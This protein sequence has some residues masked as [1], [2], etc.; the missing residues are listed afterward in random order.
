[1]K[2]SSSAKLRFADRLVEWHA[3]SG[4]HDLPWQNTRD[5]YLIWISEIMLQQTQVK[6]VIPYFAR[7]IASFPTVGSLAQADEN[8]VLAH[9]SGLGYYARG[10]NLLKAARIIATEHG[11][12]FPRAFDAICALP[13]VGRSTASAISAFAFDEKRAILDGNVKRVLSRCF[14]IEGY[15]GEKK[16]E[17]RLWALAEELL[18]DSSD[19]IKAYTQAQMDLGATVCLRSRPLCAGCPCSRVCV[20]NREKRIDEFPGRKPRRKIPSRTTA[21][22]ILISHSEVLLERRPPSGIW[23]GLWCFPEFGVDE[24]SVAKARAL[25]GVRGASGPHLTPI[26]HGFTHFNLKINPHIVQARRRDPRA[27]QPGQIWIGV[28]DALK[29]AI[30]APVRRLLQNLAPLLQKINVD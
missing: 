2:K 29:A 20:A 25:Y 21:M 7:F 10:R 13:G 18:P 1:M 23:G 9:W 6:T 28:D 24:D 26:K 3:R 11:G 4:R 19:R 17:V 12:T 8:E 27:A 22:L 15:P 14:G 30:P 5:P 16:V